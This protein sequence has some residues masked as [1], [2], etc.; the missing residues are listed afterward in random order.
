[1]QHFPFFYCHKLHIQTV[2][3]KRLFFIALIPAIL[4]SMG[5]SKNKSSSENDVLTGSWIRKG[6]D[7]TG[8]G[9]KLIFSRAAGTPMLSFNCNASP[10]S[11]PTD[12]YVPYRF[13]NNQLSYLNYTDSVGGYYPVTSFNWVVPGR[14]FSVQFHQILLYMSAV[15]EVNYEKQ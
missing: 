2:T 6:T 15:Y 14:E 3:M 4:F 1:M 10:G 8:P 12:A 13:S 11:G 5:C 7:G 9:N